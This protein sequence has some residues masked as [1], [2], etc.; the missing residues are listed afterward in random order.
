MPVVKL[1]VKAVEKLIA[2][3]PSGKQVVHWDAELKGFGVLCS[4][5]SNSKTYVAQRVLPDRRTRRVTVGAVS[6]IPLDKARQ[7]AADA[8]DDLRRGVDPKR[9]VEN[10]ALR[11]VMADYLSARKDLRPASIRVYST[12]VDKYLKPWLDSRKPRPVRV[13]ILSRSPLAK[14]MPASILSRSQRPRC[15]R[16]KAG[17]QPVAG[18]VTR[19]PPR[20]PRPNATS[21]PHKM[22]STKRAAQCLLRSARASLTIC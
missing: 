6:E 12:C 13:N 4:G 8:L 22:K 15:R 21:G 7:R 18:R 2:P 11:Q 3:N 5:V 14:L 19:L 17:S 1:N 9:K 10:P 20:R 16:P